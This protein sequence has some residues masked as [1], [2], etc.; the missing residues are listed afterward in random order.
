MRKRRLVLSGFPHH[1]ILRGNNRRRLFSYPSDYELFLRLLATAT[2]L[3]GIALHHFCLMKNHV[4]LI[5][6]PTEEAALSRWV[7]HFAQRYA[8]RRNKLRGGT[9]KLFEERYRCFPITDE[10]YFITCSA[11]VELNPI[12]AGAV[13]K[14]DDYRWSTYLLLAGA[15][16]RSALHP[17]AWTPSVFYL[18]FGSTAER[19]ATGFATWLAERCGDSTVALSEVHGRAAASAES[20]STGYARRLRRPDGT[21]CL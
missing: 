8:L 10:R 17:S 21:R 1:V 9:G 16:E 4:H 18:S 5:G 3:H 13:A 12:R 7:K 6:T 2:R 19:R 14:L 20:L 11:Y 15:A